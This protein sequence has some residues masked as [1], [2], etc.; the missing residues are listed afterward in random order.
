MQWHAGTDDAS[1]YAEPVTV[2]GRDAAGPTGLDLAMVVACVADGR[3]E[4]SSTR[5]MDLTM[6]TSSLY[7]AWAASRL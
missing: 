5:A 3:K 1:S 2:D 7:P 4:I 6:R